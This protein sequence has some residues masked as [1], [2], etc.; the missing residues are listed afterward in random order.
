[1]TDPPWADDACSLVDA[2]RA[3]ERSPRRRARSVTRR[4]RRQRPQRLLVPRSRTRACDAA[5]R[6]DVSQPFGGVPVGDQ[7]AR[8][9]RGLARDRSVAR[10]PRPGRD[11]HDHR[12]SNACSA[13]A[14]P[15]RS[16]SRP[17]ASS[18]GSTSSVTKLN[19]VTHN[20]WRHGR[21]TGRFVGRQRGRG[22]RRSRHAR[23]RRRRR[24]FDSDSRR[25]HGPARDEGHLRPHPAWPDVFFRPGTVV[26]GVPRPIRSATRRATSTCARATTGRPVEPPAPGRMGGR[27]RY[28]RPRAVAGSRSSPRS[29]ASRSSPASK[30]RVRESAPSC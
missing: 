22:R 6:A 30:Q 9:R 19:G 13:R 23:D 15:Y 1:M 21:T 4:D 2:F 14:A 18:A 27:P 5:R 12:W 3:G 16:G 11:R 26:L 28:A 24:R 17:R 7:G 29:A 10:L 8:V 25:L 20:P